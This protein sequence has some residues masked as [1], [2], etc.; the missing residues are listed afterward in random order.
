MK[1]LSVRTGLLTLLAFMTLLL[2]AVSTLGIY[3]INAGNQSL[4]VIN[5]IQGIELN[6]L[7]QSNADLMRARASGA[8]A[9]RKIEIGLLDEGAAVTK[10]A[11]ADVVTSQKHLKDFVD[12]GTVTAQGKILADAVAASFGAYLQQGIAPMMDALQKQYTD[13]Y[14]TVLEGNLSTLAANYAKAVNDFSLY[15]DQVSADRLAKAARNETQMKILIG[16]AVVLTVVLIVLAWQILRRLLLT[17]LESA[18][19]HLQRVAEGD[20][21]QTLPETTHNELGRLNQALAVMQLALRDSV[22]Q[23]REASLQIDVGS[24]ELAAG[25]VHLSQ[26]TEESAASL[27]QTAAS[28][29]QLTA[30]VRLN[31]SNAQQ[32]HQLANSV[33]D[34][35]DRG[36]EVVCYV[37]EKMQE[38]T[39]SSDRIADIL[40]VIDGIA[41]Q[42]NI[43]ALNA[44][45]EAARAGEQ[46]RGFAV[47][48]NEVRT[49]AG[50]SATAAKEIRELISD[51]QT[52]VKEGSVM[53][54]QAG[55]TMDEISSEVMR[56]T[57]LM[58]EISV[59]SE[60]Q[61]RGIE[62]VN[63]A[64][65]QMDEVAQQNA[66]LVEEAS[67]ATQSLEAQSQQLQASM[68]QFRIATA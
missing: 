2:L 46:G 7:Y 45:V 20:L 39:H 5:R 18:I 56:V 41:F 44:S 50:R 30:T 14:Y 24:R 29:E 59:S 42:T 53:A 36:A 68:A 34:T 66:A 37:I 19:G 63:Q 48:A 21:S 13:E 49:L 25:T 15:A 52:R 10:Q 26:R 60:E 12:A 32:A 6:S 1:N 27:E 31:A 65:T 62:Q 58:K 64:V 16:I 22:S 54:T 35:A 57:T 4:D 67:A 11:Q 9:V 8:L 23:V 33:S 3:A 38:I 43:L 55:E 17:P 51:S 61:S 28:M 40:S 47:V